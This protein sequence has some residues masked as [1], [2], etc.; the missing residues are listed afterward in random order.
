MVRGCII[1]SLLLVLTG[2]MFMVQLVGRPQLLI[3]VALNEY[4][5]MD[6]SPSIVQFR[7]GDSQT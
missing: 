3:G 2:T 5:V 4:L 1:H 6:A 7:F